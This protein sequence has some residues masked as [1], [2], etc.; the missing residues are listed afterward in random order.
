MVFGPHRHA[1]LLRVEARTA[2]HRPAQQNAVELQAQ[3]VVQSR[4]GVLL[5]DKGENDATV[6]AF[7]RR[8]LRLREVAHRPVACEPVLGGGHR[9]E[10]TAL[11]PGRRHVKG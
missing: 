9:F 5:H 10:R 3:V 11:L 6:A 1:L 2:W 8:F 7:A 4:G